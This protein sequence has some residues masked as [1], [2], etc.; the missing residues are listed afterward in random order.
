MSWE[1][2]LCR[3]GDDGSM[4]VGWLGGGLV[5]AGGSGRRAA[6]SEGL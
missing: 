5:G 1:G 4:E 2:V 6:G 3:Y